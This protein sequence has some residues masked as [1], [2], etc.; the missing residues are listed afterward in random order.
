MGS[1]QAVSV[2]FSP[3]NMIIIGTSLAAVPEAVRARRHSIRRLRILVV[4][5]SV[6]LSVVTAAWMILL[7]LVPSSTGRSIIGDNWDSASPLI[8]LQGLFAITLATDFGART[9]LSALEAA[10]QGMLARVWL[11]VLNISLPAAGA[12]VYGGARGILYGG[13]VAQALGTCVLFAYYLRAERSYEGLEGDAT[14]I[15]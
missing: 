7:L 4:A 5:L 10:K 6:A 15:T 3:L 13:I 14:I 9:G 12:V 1:L 8:F 2:L 11:S